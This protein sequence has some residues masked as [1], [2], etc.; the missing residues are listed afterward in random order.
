MYLPIDK[1]RVVPSKNMEESC[2]EEGVDEVNVFGLGLPSR[3][4]D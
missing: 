1:P 4:Q 2:D 3:K